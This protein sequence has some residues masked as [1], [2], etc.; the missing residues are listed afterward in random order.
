MTANARIL[1][2]LNDK[3][4][5]LSEGLKVLQEFTAEANQKNFLDS[6]RETI[7]VQDLVWVMLNGYLPRKEDWTDNNGVKTLQGWTM[8]MLH[9]SSRSL[10]RDGL[11]DYPTEM[12]Y[13]NVQGHKLE[14]SQESLSAT[15][16][17]LKTKSIHYPQQAAIISGVINTFFKMEAYPTR[18]KGVFGQLIRFVDMHHLF[19]RRIIAG[20]DA[21]STAMD[22]VVCIVPGTLDQ[23]RKLELKVR[24]HC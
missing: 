21:I 7:Y 24:T 5:P 3:K 11:P 2:D 9:N 12:D 16:G 1:I 22:K 17:L 20:Q 19:H 4:I 8:Y 23:I 14:E 15:K 13:C 6:K 18:D 10:V